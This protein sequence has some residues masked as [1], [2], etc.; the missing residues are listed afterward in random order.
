MGFKLKSVK[1]KGYKSELEV[2]KELIPLGYSCVHA[3]GSF[4]P[5]DL[6]AL[7]PGLGRLRLIQ[8]KSTGSKKRLPFTSEI[9]K[10]KAE[11]A[12]IWTS[13]ELWIRYDRR[14]WEKYTIT[15]DGDVMLTNSAVFD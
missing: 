10:I 9:K 8:V 4:G 2:I 14:G 3:G 6:W 12:P 7:H 1:Q 5:F 11:H 13:K 15:V